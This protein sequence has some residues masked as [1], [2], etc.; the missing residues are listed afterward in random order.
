MV[1]G[2]PLPA[3]PESDFGFLCPAHL[4]SD[5][6]VWQTPRKKIYFSKD[7]PEVV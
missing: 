1:L 4:V 3:P 7:T 6:C 2:L 5:E